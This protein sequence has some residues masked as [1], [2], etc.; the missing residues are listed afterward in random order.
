M[1]HNGSQYSFVGTSMGLDP[2]SMLVFVMAQSPSLTVNGGNWLVSPAATVEANG[3]WTV[4]WDVRNL[5]T[6]VKWVAVIYQSSQG[7]CAPEATCEAEPPQPSPG[8]SDASN[9]DPA[10]AS[11][12]LSR[13]GPY[14]DTLAQVAFTPTP[15][16]PR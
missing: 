12:A 6:R 5:P 14:Q 16:P 9:S 11:A 3:R 2:N 13:Y 1:S 8:D 10:Q 4:T 7:S 15:S